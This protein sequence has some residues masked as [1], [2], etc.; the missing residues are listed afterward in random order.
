M[1]T[2]PISLRAA[3][4]NGKWGLSPFSCRADV[5]LIAVEREP[6]LDHAHLVVRLLVAPDRVFRPVH[7]RKIRRIALE[8]AVRP[9]ARADQP[10]HLHVLAG[11]IE[12]RGIAALLH[13]DG[14]AR[15]GDDF[16]F[17]RHA[18][19]LLRG[20]GLDAMICHFFFLLAAFLAGLRA[21]AGAAFH[22]PF[23]RPSGSVN[24]D[25]QPMPGTSC[26]STWITPPAST[27]FLR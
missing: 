17:E 8:R 23:M 24:S 10:L 4:S 7:Q 14:V 9:M 12:D 1:G 26:S 5:H 11:E 13:P 2:D 21:A 25:S 3:R 18:H 19:A 16:A 22:R 27:I 6:L 20:L 15:V